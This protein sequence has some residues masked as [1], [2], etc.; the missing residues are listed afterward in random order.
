MPPSLTNTNTNTYTLS[1]SLSFCIDLPCM[2]LSEEKGPTRLIQLQ[3][4]LVLAHELSLLLSGHGGQLAINQIVPA[5]KEMF[6]R[7]LVLSQFGFPKLIKAL[8]AMPD[9]ITV[10]VGWSVRVCV[11]F[12]LCMCE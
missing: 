4:Q 2:Q 5:Y 3:P 9:T 8:E 1:L 11:W 10:S 7:N 6:G 12:C